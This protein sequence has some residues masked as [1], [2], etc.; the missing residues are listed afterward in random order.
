MTDFENIPFDDQVARLD[1]IADAMVTVVREHEPM[2]SSELL[3]A[4]TGTGWDADL[5]RALTHAVS[6]HRLRRNWDDWTL[7]VD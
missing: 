7:T 3:D 1:D 4:M 2:T 6:T 5:R